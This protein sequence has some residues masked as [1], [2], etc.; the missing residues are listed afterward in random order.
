MADSGVHDRVVIV[1]GRG[2]GIGRGLVRH[3]GRA[4]ARIVV[5][6]WN[7]ERLKDAVTELEGAGVTCL[8]VECDVS[9]R[10]SIDA[11]VG[12]AHRRFGR[13]DGLVNNAMTITDFVPLAELTEA[14]LDVNLTSGLKG[15]LWAMQAVYPHMQAAGWGRIVNV[16]SAAG[17]VGFKGMGAYA[18]TKEAIRALTRTAAREW[19]ADGIVVN[20]Y[21]PVST[22]HYEGTDQLL[23]DY[24][25]E[26]MAVVR[27]LSP[28][29]HD[30]DAQTD[31]GPVVE[32]L[33]SD[34]CRYLTGQTL[35]LDGGTYAFA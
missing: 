29:G 3:L 23:T 11:M 19:A 35:M 24:K 12:A 31:I 5:A 9:D 7:P 2:A 28:T 33:L 32:F 18:A 17:I 21:C 30:G 4:G 34:A 13:I 10:A 27:A 16:G 22:G 14:Q 8:G 6:E 20:L 1:T 25:Q 15:T 26:G